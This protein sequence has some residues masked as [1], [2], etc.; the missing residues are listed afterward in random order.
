MRNKKEGQTG[1]DFS[2]D[3]IDCPVMKEVVE[4]LK[5]VSA[6]KSVVWNEKKVQRNVWKDEKKEKKSLKKIKDVW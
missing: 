6:W 5:P 1:Q 3:E 2:L 4:P